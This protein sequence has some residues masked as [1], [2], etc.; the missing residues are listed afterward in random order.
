MKYGL[1]YQ[2]SKSAIAKWVVAQIP[3]ADVFVD[4]FAG[5]CAV[6][7]CALLSGK[8]KKVIANDITAEPKAFL[9]AVTDGV[10]DKHFVTKEEFVQTDDQLVK[11]VYSFGND[12]KH[13][14][15]SEEKQTLANAFHK[16]V[17]D[18]DFQYLQDI[19]DIDFQEIAK[20][21]YWYDSYLTI[22]DYI[23]KRRNTLIRIEH[24]ERINRIQALNNP[25]LSRKAESL[26]IVQG[27][28]KNLEIPRNSVVYADIPYKSKAKY[29]ND[30][31]HE[32]FYLWCKRQTQPL[33]ISEYAMPEDFTETASVKKLN[34]MCA[35]SNFN[36]IEKLFT[37][38]SPIYN[39]QPTLF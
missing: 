5:G 7:H 12:C 25:V 17:F 2:G 33:Y 23:A 10:K 20:S 24:I 3:P 4:L 26:Q 38:N 29:H 27:D 22:K 11:T 8:F 34:Q 37:Y 21:R 28:Y 16:A 19:T 18:N 32:E 1:P 13:Y 36:N 39:D 15:Y 9:Q 35:K 6:T 30:F 14:I 31:D